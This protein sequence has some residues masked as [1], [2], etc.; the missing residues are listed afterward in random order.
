MLQK[1]THTSTHGDYVHIFKYI[2]MMYTYGNNTVLT[3]T[4]TRAY[5][6]DG[7]S[8]IHVFFLVMIYNRLPECVCVCA[9]VRGEIV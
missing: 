4:H 1:H 9:V 2:Y 8:H 6:V 5:K 3:L 7:W